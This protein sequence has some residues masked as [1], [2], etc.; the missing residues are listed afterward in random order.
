MLNIHD[1]QRWYLGILDD[2]KIKIKRQKTMTKGH[3]RAP[4]EAGECSNNQWRCRVQP[5]GGGIDQP[6]TLNTN[7][8]AVTKGNGM[9]MKGAMERCMGSG[10]KCT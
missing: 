5:R 6:M 1:L 8:W 9:A 10:D 3:D 7:K 2:E 4:R